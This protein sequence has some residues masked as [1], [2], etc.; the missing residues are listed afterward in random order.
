MAFVANYIC[1][2]LSDVSEW[3]K[4]LTLSTLISIKALKLNFKLDQKHVGSLY[5][6]Y[7]T[8]VI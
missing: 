8:V 4:M 1:G 3:K 5:R 6:Q 2:Q 7:E